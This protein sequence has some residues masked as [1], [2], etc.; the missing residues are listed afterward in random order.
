MNPKLPVVKV[1][2]RGVRVTRVEMDGH[3][4][5]FVTEVESR[6]PVNGMPTVRVTFVA[7]TVIEDTLS[8]T[9]VVKS[10]EE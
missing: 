4:L 2:R 7:E 1:T 6:L 8:V 3:E 10:D 9:Y 5:P